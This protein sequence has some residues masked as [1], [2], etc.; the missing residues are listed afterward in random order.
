MIE[1]IEEHSNVSITN[2]S[3]PEAV[4]I[5]ILDAAPVVGALWS[6]PYIGSQVAVS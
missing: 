3:I 5:R 2:H 4:L 1:V 6:D